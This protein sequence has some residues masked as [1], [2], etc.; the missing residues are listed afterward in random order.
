MFQTQTQYFPITQVYTSII[1]NIKLVP[2]PTTRLAQREFHL[3][4]VL[5]PRNAGLKEVS[6]QDSVFPSGGGS[7]GGFRIRAR[8]IGRI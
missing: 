2:F 8:G 1:Q 6:Y 3:K 7:V 4:L 5:V